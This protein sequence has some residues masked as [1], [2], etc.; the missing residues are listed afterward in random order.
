MLPRVHQAHAVRAIERSVLDGKRHMVVSMASGSGKTFT[1]IYAIN[2]LM[3]IGAATRVLYL[4]DRRDLVNQIRQAIEV[5]SIETGHRFADTYPVLGYEE[6]SRIGEPDD[7]ARFVCAASV[8]AVRSRL[9]ALEPDLVDLVVYEGAST[10]DFRA[11]AAHFRATTISF[12]PPVKPDDVTVFQYSPEQAIQDGVLVDHRSARTRR[13]ANDESFRIRAGQRVFLLTDDSDRQDAATIAT[14]LR[15]AGFDVRIDSSSEVLRSLPEI[16]S[17]DT[18]VVLL[19]PNSIEALAEDGVDT[20]LDRRG[21]ELLPAVL[22][23]CSIPRSLADRGVVDVTVG[24]ASL[25]RALRWADAINIGAMNAVTF[26]SLAADLLTR[27][28]FTLQPPPQL[29]T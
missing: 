22:K 23:P 17:D 16:H 21:A 1:A 27:I 26:E 2:R 6:L 5:F 25:I 8:Q 3:G 10:A 28:G 24:A 11:V 29:A 12:G 15:S 7:S 14:E 18:M 19:T 20:A 4:A 13:F 9:H